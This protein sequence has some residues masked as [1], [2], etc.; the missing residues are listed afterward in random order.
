[1]TISAGASTRAIFFDVDFTLIRPGP[2][3]QGEG[4]RDVCASHGIGVEPGRF[5]EAVASASV[6]LD[7]VQDHIYDPELFIDYTQHVIERMGGQGP[8][9]RAC[10]REIYESWAENHHFELYDDVF[11]T[12]RSLSARGIRLGLISNTHRS[13]S[14]FQSHFG[15]DDLISVALSSS[16]HGYMKPHRSIFEAALELAGVSAGEAVMVG[17]SYRHDIEGALQVGMRAVLL[18][19]SGECSEGGDVVP[20]IKGLLELHSLV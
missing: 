14:A 20:V 1:M 6:V 19:R 7:R 17:D 3:F 4:Y 5:L 12:L 13:L 11:E 10:A 15:L 8:A 18:C 2:R 16:A 9:V